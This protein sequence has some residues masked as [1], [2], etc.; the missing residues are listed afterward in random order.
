MV[1]FSLKKYSKERAVWHTG[2]HPKISFSHLS[3]Q[4]AICHRSRCS[5]K[6]PSP[7]CVLSSK[8]SSCTLVSSLFATPFPLIPSRQSMPL[9]NYL[10]S[11][12]Q[13]SLLGMQHSKKTAP[14]LKEQPDWH[15]ALTQSGVG[16]DTGECVMLAAHGGCISQCVF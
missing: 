9:S 1:F 11:Q 4:R 7:L 16:E 3:P 13:G 15:T 8:T 5:P 2:N 6:A 10:S 12:A 14:A